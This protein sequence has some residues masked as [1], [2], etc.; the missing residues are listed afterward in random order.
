M[1]TVLGLD[2]R[3][4]AKQK[5]FIWLHDT[6]AERVPLL[7]PLSLMMHSD[8]I[9]DMAA[10]LAALKLKPTNNITFRLAGEDRCLV[11]RDD[12]K[13]WWLSY[14]ESLLPK[15]DDVERMRCFVTGEIVIPAS[16]HPKLKL[17]SVGGQSAGSTLIGFDK[18]S[19]ASFGLEQS[20]NAACSEDAAAIYA[21]A[22]D[23]LIVNAPPLA[24][25][26]FSTDDR[27]RPSQRGPVRISSPRRRIGGEREG[28]GMAPMRCADCEAVPTESGPSHG[29]GTMRAR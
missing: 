3:S 18:K 24:Q 11:E 25:L 26:W 6:A 29:I 9:A 16:T 19:F 5:A 20:A 8:R 1:A 21:G 12:W 10:N 22:L 4:A 27:H 23:D 13:D 2:D 7:K 15:D 17:A 28:K 14:R